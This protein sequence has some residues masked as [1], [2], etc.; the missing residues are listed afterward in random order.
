MNDIILNPL[1]AIKDQL[2]HHN[3]IKR[4]VIINPNV[5]LLTLEVN[6]S[7]ENVLEL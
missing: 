4:D 5:A 7:D 1:V 3:H 6:L 2:N